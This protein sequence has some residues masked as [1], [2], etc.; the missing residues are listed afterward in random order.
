[1]RVVFRSLA[2]IGVLLS[3]A[4]PVARES[5]SARSPQERETRRIEIIARRFAFYTGDSRWPI[6]D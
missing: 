2:A 5:P 4:S 6:S 3:V 1:M